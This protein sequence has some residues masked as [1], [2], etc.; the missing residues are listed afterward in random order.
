M[1]HGQDDLQEQRQRENTE[2]QRREPREK[3]KRMGSRNIDRE[4]TLGGRGGQS[5][6]RMCR[7]KPLSGRDTLRREGERLRTNKD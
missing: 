4:M 1:R 5:L 3:L 7:E 2:R 6:T